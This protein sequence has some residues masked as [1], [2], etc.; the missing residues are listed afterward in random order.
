MSGPTPGPR[1]L[2]LCNDLVYLLNFRTP[3][4]EEMTA[5]GCAVTVVGPPPTGAQSEALARLSVAFKPWRLR[6][7]GRN[8]LAEAASFLALVAIV[9]RVRPD[10]LF[11][12]AIKPVIYGLWAAALS[13]VPRRVAMITGLG[14]AFI[15]GKG[16]KRRLTRLVAT[17]AY[18]SA[19]ARANRV[20][21][22]NRDDE[23]HF[24]E[25]GVV[26]GAERTALVAGSGVDL[27]A[28]RFEPLPPGP[29]SFLMVARLLRDKGVYEYAEAA[30]LVRRQIPDA[31]FRL[32]GDGDENPA[33]VGKAEI[34][35]WAEEGVIEPLGHLDDVRPALAACQVFVLPSYREG[36]PRTALEALAT[37]R[38]IV[39]TDVPGC[40]DTVEPGRNGWLAAPRDAESLA[41]A[42]L[43]AAA[44]PAVLTAMG[45]RSRALAEARFDARKVARDTAGL[46]LGSGQ[47][48]A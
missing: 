7:T 17:L 20:I 2:V 28:Y 29:P 21:F 13:R 32:A 30:R 3:L 33:A 47:A 4:I 11:A 40:R 24:R 39:T 15:E 26:R 34:A 12:Y 43:Q 45:E 16:L 8:P 46:I 9:R 27:D 38:A 36:L 18:R 19:L 6:K 42:M 14:Y 37:G 41:R 5:R 22:Q 48:E 31:R 10:I 44:D 25:L 35:R 23:V 1:V